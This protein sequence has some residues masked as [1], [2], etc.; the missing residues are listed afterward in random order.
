MHYQRDFKRTEG[1]LWAYKPHP[2]PGSLGL[3]G[4]GQ[5]P[6]PRREVIE[7]LHSLTYIL[8]PFLG[9]IL[10]IPKLHLNPTPALDSEH[11]EQS[12]G[13]FYRGDGPHRDYYLGPTGQGALEGRNL[14]D[15]EW[16]AQALEVVVVV[17]QHQVGGMG[18][19]RG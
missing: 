10:G 4:N 8:I 9:L 5:S 1:T 14:L 12:T 11:H 13:V 2:S 7:L 19:K 18:V 15:S 16:L 17:P 6:L 3:L